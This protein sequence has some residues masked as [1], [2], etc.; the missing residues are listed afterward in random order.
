MAATKKKAQETIK[1]WVT[2]LL[3]E[4]VK[5]DVEL[6]ICR[7]FQCGDPKCAPIDTAIQVMFTDRTRPPLQI[8]LPM[9]CQQLTRE[10]VEDGVK[11]MLSPPEE[12]EDEFDPISPAATEVFDGLVQD[13]FLAVEKYEQRAMQMQAASKRQQQQRTQN[14]GVNMLLSYAQQNK[15]E[16][17]Q[18]LLDSGGGVDPSEGNS[19]GQTALHVACLWGNVEAAGCLISNEAGVNVRNDLTGGTPLHITVCSPKAL[20]GRLACAKLLLDAGAD[21]LLEDK[22]SETAMAAAAEELGTL[23]GASDQSGFEALE[24]GG[25]EDDDD[26]P[27]LLEGG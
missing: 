24:Y 14:P 7:E 17:L 2:S 4:D 16:E 9:E 13:M 21:P 11:R 1:E 23:L 5:K 10:D 27:G 26:M 12:E 3:P 19:V 6:I 22:R 15:P 25:D 18:R 20:E 8:G